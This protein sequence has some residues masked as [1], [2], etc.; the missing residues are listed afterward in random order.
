MN[1][2]QK[3]K[4]MKA[5]LRNRVTGGGLSGDAGVGG[6]ASGASGLLWWHWL[7]I[8]IVVLIVIIA[9]MSKFLRR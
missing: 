3:E 8:A 7:I 9:G 2:Q 1:P 5:R 4:M 6:A